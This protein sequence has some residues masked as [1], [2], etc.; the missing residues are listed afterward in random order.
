MGYIL[1]KFSLLALDKPG[2]GLPYNN[3]GRNAHSK[4]NWTFHFK[5]QNI[6]HVGPKRTPV[7]T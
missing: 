3:E 1:I 4:R 7:V 2:L 6:Y 5:N